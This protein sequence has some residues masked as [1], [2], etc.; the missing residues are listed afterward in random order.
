MKKYAVVEAADTSVKLALR[1]AALDS[2]GTV[3]D[4]GIDGRGEIGTEYAVWIIGVTDI[5]G[6]DLY[7]VSDAF[8]FIDDIPPHLLSAVGVTVRDV[9]VFFDEAVT[10][11]TAGDE[12]NYTLYPSGD[13]LSDIAVFQAERLMDQKSVRLLL[14]EDMA[15]DTDYTL[16]VTGVM[17]LAGYTMDPDSVEFHFLDE[18]PPSILRVD[19]INPTRLAIEFSE[20]VD[21]ATAVDT[22]NYSVYMTANSSQVIAVPSIDWMTDEVRLDLAETP[23]PNVNY[24]VKIDGVEDRFGNV[25]TD[26]FG[27][28][29]Y[30]VY[31]PSSILYLFDD[32][33]RS[34]QEIDVEHNQVFSFYVWVE[35]GSNGVY[36]VEY[37]LSE[38]QTYFPTAVTL[39]PVYVS[40]A[41]GDPYAGHSVALSMCAHDW[42]W[43][44]RI[45]AFYFDDD[46]QEIVWFQPHPD[47]GGVIHVATCLDGHPL[48]PVA[49]TYPLLI[50]TEY[51]GTLLDSWD[52]SFRSGGIELSWS[53]LETGDSPEFDVSRTTEGAGSW[54][55]LDSSLI[56]SDGLRYT[57]FDSDL[58]PGLSYRYRVEYLEDDGRKV[59]FE[60]GAVSTPVMPLALRQNS[61]NPFN[62]VTSI[63]FYLPRPG[64]VRLEIFDVNGREISVLA[65]G[66]YASGEYSV[67][68]NGRDR[69]GSMAASGVYFYRLT[70]GKESLSR[71]MVLLR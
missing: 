61:P 28:F 9:Y 47:A 71:K 10:S 24:T 57:M 56:R 60:T 52:A 1:S 63:G 49:G 69:T 12:Q 5:A 34:S 17:D 23:V 59:L 55:Q 48:E 15:Q 30:D 42:F 50:N 18:T 67:E 53:I 44:A 26:L 51:I 29:R 54:R 21:S 31:V 66:H 32:E 68:W 38:P 46:E 6:N 62:P 33:Y 25:A 27:A 11:V 36:G 64:H 19:L 14:S 3:V 13:P 70:A 20:P 40:V 35:P 45:D 22:G 16:E 2:A 7:T 58:E 65:D 43:A 41:M 37:A 8:Q 39:N 4:L